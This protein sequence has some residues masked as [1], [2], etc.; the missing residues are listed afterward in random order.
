MGRASGSTSS[1]SRSGGADGAY[2]KVDVL[3]PAKS[4][5]V[6]VVSRLRK[7]AALDTVPD[8]HPEGHQHHPARPTGW[9]DDF[10]TDPEAAV[11]DIPGVVADRFSLLE[12]A[13]R[14]IRRH[15]DR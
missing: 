4:Q 6:T 7:D 3:K 9:R 2:A 14:Q 8:P 12:I 1:G 11:A 15:R 10:C 13:F 5:R